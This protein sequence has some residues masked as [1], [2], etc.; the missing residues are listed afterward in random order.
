M[1]GSMALT[2]PFTGFSGRLEIGKL[3]TPGKKDSNV[4][5]RDFLN[6]LENNKINFPP[7]LQL[8]IEQLRKDINDGLYMVSDIPQ[9][10]G[11]GSSGV[12]VASVYSQYSLQPAGAEMELDLFKLKNYFSLM[13]SYFHGKSSGLDPLSCFIQKP[14]LVSSPVKTESIEVNLK[15]HQHLINIFLLDTGT[16]SQT[17]G[18]VK[19]FLERSARPEFQQVLDT[20]II[21]C[22]NNCIKT[23][24]EDRIPDFLNEVKKLSSLQF[25]YFKEM[26]PGHFTKV[27]KNGLEKGDYS[28]KLCG[29]GGGG[30]ILGFTSDYQKCEKYFR[31]QGITVLRFNV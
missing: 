31:N 17:G 28:L 8:D 14:L 20:Q 12:L 26:I 29:S 15:D 11:A 5:L 24:L 22:N 18:L 13:E 10:Y 6:Y 25:E 19:L 7:G 16:S 1:S 27:W 4:N 30:F 23:L 2:V 21:P 3:N 9:G